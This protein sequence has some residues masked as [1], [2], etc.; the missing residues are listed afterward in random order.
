MSVPTR[1]TFKY[2]APT[3]IAFVGR[4][5]GA[6]AAE[7]TPLETIETTATRHEAMGLDVAPGVT[8]ISVQEI[9]RHL[10]LTVV[11]HLRG[12]PGTYVIYVRRHDARCLCAF[13]LSSVILMQCAKIL[14]TFKRLMR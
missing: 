7:E 5:F 11:D 10:P 14:L 13:T 8:T 12:E 3:L 4:R 2:A 1:A 9:A 6:A